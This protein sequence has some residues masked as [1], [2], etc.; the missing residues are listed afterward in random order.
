MR[1]VRR[2]TPSLFICAALLSTGNAH[3]QT[4]AGSAPSSSAIADTQITAFEAVSVIPMDSDRVLPNQTVLTRDGRITAIGPAG[5]LS[6]PPQTRR[7]DGRGLFLMPGLVDMHV[8]LMGGDEMTDEFPMFLAYG[9]TT[10]RQMAG[11]PSVLA[12]RRRVSAGEVLGPTIFTVG[13]LIDGSPPVFP[14]GSIVATTP[15]QARE[16]ADPQKQA[17]YDQI[18]A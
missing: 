8:H 1:R 6:I 15:E 18:T 12:M 7:I 10:I 5:T 4:D 14:G 2:A 13:V 16:A 3:P 9:V 11:A 17:R